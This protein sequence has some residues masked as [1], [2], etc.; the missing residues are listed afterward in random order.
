MTKR[1]KTIA[2]LTEKQFLN[3][4]KFVRDRDDVTAVEVFLDDIAKG[5]TVNEVL[6]GEQPEKG[7]MVIGNP[8]PYEISV[9]EVAPL[10]YEIRLGCFPGPECGDEGAWEVTF[11]GKGEV[12]E[13]IETEYIIS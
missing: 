10:K 13:A 8:D 3:F 12:I 11:N 9:R 6:A 5:K 7:V 1:N 2:P 4:L